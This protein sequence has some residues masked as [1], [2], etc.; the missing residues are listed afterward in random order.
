MNKLALAVA[1]TSLVFL[2]GGQHAPKPTYRQMDVTVGGVHTARYLQTKYGIYTWTN[3]MP[4]N[5]YVFRSY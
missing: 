5:C 2:A 4:E 1:L 3:G